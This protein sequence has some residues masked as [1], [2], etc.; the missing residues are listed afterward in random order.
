MPLT[1]SVVIVNYNGWELLRDCLTSLAHQERPADEIIVVDNGS[2]DGTVDRLPQAF[3]EVRLIPS[4]VNLGFAK[5]NNL[6]IARA[7]GEVVILLNNDTV[8]DPGFVRAL[9]EPL[10]RDA[11]IGAVASTM[12]F[13]SRPDIVASAGIEVYADGLALDRGLGLQ[14][15]DLSGETPVFGASAGAAAYRRTAVDE[16][17]RFPEAFFMYLEDVDLAWRLRLAGWDV[18][19][20]PDAVVEH[21]YSASAIEGSPA[22]RRFLA[23]NRLWVIARC[24]PTALLRRHWHQILRYEAMAGGYALIRRDWPALIGRLAAIIGL[25][26]RLRER[27]AIQRQSTCSRSLACWLKP[28]LPP[29]EVLRLRRLTAELAAGGER[30]DG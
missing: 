2:S 3:P 22:K 17:G 19:H 15:S 28:P 12:V 9:V 20:A 30:A 26:A 4:P 21:H 24:M 23:R 29:A 16:V 13:S 6:G 25:Q 18:V 8:A 1:V 7:H 5:G 27:W 10:E 11:R 14:R